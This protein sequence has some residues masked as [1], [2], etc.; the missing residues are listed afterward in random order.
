MKYVNIGDNKFDQEHMKFLQTIDGALDSA[1]KDA[2][3]QKLRDQMAELYKRIDPLARTPIAGDNTRE[4]KVAGD[5]MRALIKNDKELARNIEQKETLWPSHV[6][7]TGGNE[8]IDTGSMNQGG[9][10]IPELLHNEIARIIEE[11]GVSRREMMYLPFAGAGNERRLP[12]ETTSPSVSWI[13][14]GQQ[15]PPTKPTIGQVIQTLEKLA[16]ITILTDELIEDANFD[17]I[18]YLGRRFAEVIAVEEDNQF[19]AGVGA[20]WT[21]LIN[22][23]GIIP[24]SV[25]VGVLAANVTPEDMLNLK[26]A[27]PTG[28]RRGGKYYMNPEVWAALR[29]YRA[30]TI[31]SGD[32]EGN[33]LLQSPL[34]GTPNLL[35]GSPVVEV[36]ALPGIA[37]ITAPDEPFALFGNLSRAAVYG[38]K[39]GTRIKLLDQATVTDEA[40]T[41]INLAERDMTA[42]RVMRRVGYVPLLPGAIS[43]LHS[44]PVS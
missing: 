41:S 39:A 1:V 11:A 23:A 21:G 44:G 19:F 35:W 9:Y 43:C 22:A 33:Y 16:A 3:T 36:D 18:S 40:G 30:S 29:S 24:V 17:I 28:A 37:D 8:N 38:D 6:L 32:K 26:Y 15:K 20:P 10:L 14:E 34:D 42:V 7:H 2:G 31:A 5:F 4:R 12:V 27:L 25:N 13:A